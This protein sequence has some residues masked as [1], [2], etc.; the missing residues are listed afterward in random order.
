MRIQQMRDE[1]VDDE[2]IMAWQ[3]QL[4]DV[5]NSWMMTETSKVQDEPASNQSSLKLPGTELASESSAPPTIQSI[6]KQMRAAGV[7]EETIREHVEE[8]VDDQKFGKSTKF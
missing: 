7:D 1:G 3:K 2:G 4:D 6:I 5:R 8:K